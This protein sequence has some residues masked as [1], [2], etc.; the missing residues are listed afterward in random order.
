[1]VQVFVSENPKKSIGSDISI[2]QSKMNRE[3][4]TNSMV[5]EKMSR[6][7]MGAPI[8]SAGAEP[9]LTLPVLVSRS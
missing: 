5:V 1:M 3:V 8:N 4:S 9:Y 2:D 6:L 7:K